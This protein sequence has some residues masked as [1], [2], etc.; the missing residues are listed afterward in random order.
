SRTA[1][2]LS[3]VMLVRCHLG[4]ASPNCA[5]SLL[6]NFRR[7]PHQLPLQTAICKFLHLR[8]LNPK[9]E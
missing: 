9:N 4:V 5:W 7:H 1:R 2:M 3:A 6:Q 8:G